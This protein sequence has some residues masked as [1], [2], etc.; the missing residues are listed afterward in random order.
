MEHTPTDRWLAYELHDGL[1]QWIIGAR[2]QLL[3]ALGR[4]DSSESSS[5]A[6]VRKA[7]TSL[8]IAL[9]EG[10]ELIGYLEQEQAPAGIKFAA[11]LQ[12]FIDTTQRAHEQQIVLK[13]EPTAQ[14]ELPD[15]LGD[16]D[17]WN[18]LRIV[19]QA[20][21][22]AV[23]HA[24]KTR[25][26]VHCQVSAGEISGGRDLVVTVSD[27][28]KGFDLRRPTS[29]SNHFGLNSMA[30]RARLIGAQLTIDSHVGAGCRVECRLQLK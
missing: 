26:D 17:S 16:K 19:E 11:R 6:S 13:F 5:H 10:R 24:G 2:L 12:D 3:A 15:G 20:I 18:L 28:G 23:Q 25:I 21:R 22:N 1:L 27:Q 7:L 9:E 29:D 4:D 8:E 30:H 14:S